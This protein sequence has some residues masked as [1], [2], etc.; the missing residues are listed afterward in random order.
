MQGQRRKRLLLNRLGG[1]DAMAGMLKLYLVSPG[2]AL[3]CNDGIGIEQRQAD[4]GL[5]AVCGG[6]RSPPPGQLG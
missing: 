2:L 5:T 3:S 4:A 1:S 6:R